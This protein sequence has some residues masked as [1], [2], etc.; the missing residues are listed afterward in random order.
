MVRGSGEP[1][2]GLVAEMGAQALGQFR[3]FESLRALRL[4][5]ILVTR[6]EFRV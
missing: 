2:H 4:E 6:A 3:P 5:K 1:A